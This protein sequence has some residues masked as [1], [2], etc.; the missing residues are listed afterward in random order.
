MVERAL[1]DY[2]L[3]CKKMSGRLLD[4]HVYRAEVKGARKVKSVWKEKGR[5]GE[6]EGGV[7]GGMMR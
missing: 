3:V 2:I 5:K 6:K 1:M 7:N 4:V